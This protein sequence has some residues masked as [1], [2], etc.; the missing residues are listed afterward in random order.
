MSQLTALAHVYCESHLPP[1]EYQTMLSTM[2]LYF[3]RVQAFNFTGHK[4]PETFFYLNILDSLL[5][6]FQ[7]H[8][9]IPDQGI[10]FDIGTGGGFPGVPVA[11][12][13]PNAQYYLV[14]SV[15]KKLK[16]IQEVKDK[17]QLQHIHPMHQ[18]FEMLG[19]NPKWRCK[20]D[21]VLAKAVAKW[22][23]LLEYALP[24][25]NIGGTFYAYQSLAI[26][27]ELQHNK[28]LLTRLGGEV[29]GVHEYIL[30]DSLG[31]RCIVEIVKVASTPKEYPRNMGIPKAQPLHIG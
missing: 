16:L 31:E 26:K 14:D 8:I 30:P 28:K 7:E 10:I 25:L 21:V 11:I 15:E 19:Q 29:R 1:K 17:F 23:T 12:A 3:S 2:D 22:P 5:P 6:I 9:K 20:V 27:E 13:K 18:R 24:L 4:T